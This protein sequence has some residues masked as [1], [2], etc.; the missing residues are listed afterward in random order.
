MKC[1]IECF[2]T[3]HSRFGAT[4]WLAK[5]YGY[6]VCGLRN[7]IAPGK[8]PAVQKRCGKIKWVA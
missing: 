2:G 3:N 1:F 7:R 8:G 6:A 5:F 4:N